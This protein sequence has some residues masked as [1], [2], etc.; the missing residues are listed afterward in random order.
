MDHKKGMEEQ[1]KERD[2][3]VESVEESHNPCDAISVLDAAQHISMMQQSERPW[4]KSHHGVSYG[5]KRA[6]LL[7]EEVRNRDL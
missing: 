6:G 1:W 4:N 3:C 7:R 5:I 2:E